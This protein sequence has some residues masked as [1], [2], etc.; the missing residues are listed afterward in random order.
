MFSIYLEPIVEALCELVTIGMIHTLRKAVQLCKIHLKAA[1]AI[2][3]EIEIQIG[4]KLK[5]KDY[6]LVIQFQHFK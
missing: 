4:V 3:L 6:Q 2:S 5:Y 1:M